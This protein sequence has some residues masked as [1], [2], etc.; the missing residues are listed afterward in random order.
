MAD[1]L[2]HLSFNIL[3]TRHVTNNLTKDITITLKILIEKPKE[4][5][6]AVH[7]RLK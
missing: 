2:R 3:E 4:K 7:I 5:Y 6:I 1:G